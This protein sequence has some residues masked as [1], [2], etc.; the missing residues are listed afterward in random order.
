MHTFHL[1]KLETL[2]CLD[3][4]VVNILMSKLDAHTMIDIDD[5][6]AALSTGTSTWGVKGLAMQA[7]THTDQSSLVLHVITKPL[8]GAQPVPALRPVPG[9]TIRRTR[10]KDY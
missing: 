9:Y 1:L 4:D 5:V 8:S 10:G 7:P 2:G 3:R 6:V